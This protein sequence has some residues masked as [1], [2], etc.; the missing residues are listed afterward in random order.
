MKS[1]KTLATRKTCQCRSPDTASAM[2]GSAIASDSVTSRMPTTKRTGR[3]SLTE[4][5]GRCLS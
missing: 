5:I 3:R 4:P 2:A 1:V